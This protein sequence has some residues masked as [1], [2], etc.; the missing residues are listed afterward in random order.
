[1]TNYHVLVT[2]PL[3]E[4]GLKMLEETPDVTFIAPGK[5]A[6][7]DVLAAIPQAHALLLRSGTK[8]DRELIEAAPN[9]KIIG[10]AGVGVDNID[11]EAASEYGIV[12]MNAPDSNTVAVAELTL[13]LMI[14]LARQIPAAHES[15]ATGEWKR[16]TFRGTEL[17]NK[18]LGIVGMGR[19]GQAVTRRAAAFEMCVYC[20]DPLFDIHEIVAGCAECMETDDVLAVSDYISLHAP[21]NQ[22]TRHMINAETI[23]KMK[24]GVRIINTARGALIDAGAL[25]AAIK[26]GKVAGAAVDV[27][28][29]E[30][31]GTDNPLVGLP[32]VIHVPHIGANTFEAQ[33]EVAL[34]TVQQML[35][36][37]FKGEFRNVVNPE[38]F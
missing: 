30:P 34:Q 18:C 23:A 29:P 24:D 16:S 5:M 11:L 1:M 6:R 13:G 8:A 4:A 21:L 33:A 20:T 25:A 7:D 14:S 28:E 32:G 9:L 10:R 22:E 26:S 38:V 17:R 37:F 31:P 19:I 27:Y 15:L 2:D 3:H 35:D 12:V 36:G